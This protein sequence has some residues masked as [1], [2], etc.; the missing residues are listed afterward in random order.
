M[1]ADGP[2][3]AAKA[4]GEA[5]NIESVKTDKDKVAFMLMILTTKRINLCH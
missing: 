1:T 4:L 3:F 5:I 2:R